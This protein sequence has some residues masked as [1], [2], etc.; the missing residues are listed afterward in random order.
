M[1]APIAQAVCEPFTLDD[2]TRVELHLMDPE[3]AA[4]LVRFH[5]TLSPETT[6]LRFFT[7]HPELSSEEVARFTTVDHVAREALV[8]TVDGHVVAVARFDRLDDDEAEVAF[9]VADHLQG[10][11][12][13]ST[14]FARLAARGRELG[15]RRFVAETLPYNGRMLHVFRNGGLPCRTSF[16]DGV[17]HVV[18][19]L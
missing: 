11:G 14:L 10:R 12:I 16:G 15:I 4:E 8:A 19:D 2:A 6:H 1:S 7:T 18:I 13:G 5:H 17:T 9:V 3:D